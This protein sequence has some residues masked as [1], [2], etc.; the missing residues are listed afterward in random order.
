M[1]A[2]QE[3]EAIV[4]WLRSLLPGFQKES[5]AAADYTYAAARVLADR[6]ENNEHHGGTP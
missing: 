1:T 5:G 4:K 2:E 3:R 6:I